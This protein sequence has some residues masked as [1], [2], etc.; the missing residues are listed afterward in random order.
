MVDTTAAGSTEA[1]VD[2]LAVAFCLLIGWLKG[3][4]VGE[5]GWRGEGEAAIRG[6]SENRAAADSSTTDGG[7]PDREK[8]IPTRRRRTGSESERAEC[9]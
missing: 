3:A 1:D 4:A 5:R 9:V 6:G 8:S 7:R 2:E